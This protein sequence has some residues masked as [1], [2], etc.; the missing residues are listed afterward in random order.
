MS[1]LV[2]ARKYRP[3]TFSEVVGQE[4]VTRTLGNAFLHRSQVD[5]WT[6]V[7]HPLLEYP[8]TPVGEIERRIAGHVADLIPDGA[9]VQ[10]GVGSIPQAV[11]EALAG[12]KDLGVHSLL[13]DHMLPLVRSGVI[14][15]A[16]KRLH[17]G[18]IIDGKL[19]GHHRPHRVPDDGRAVDALGLEES[20]EI[21]GE[22]RHAIRID[23]LARLPVPSLRDREDAITWWQVWQH[24]VP[25]TA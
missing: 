16:R 21:R 18:R 10:L 20:G 22:V 25:G 13:V 4:H 11:M 7:D 6:A 9:T 1:Y 17:P 3:T 23:R 5:A 15:N 8:P 24:Q 14:T 19:L 12:K 2:L